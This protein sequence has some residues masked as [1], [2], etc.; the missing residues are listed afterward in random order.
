MID[1]YTRFWQPAALVVSDME[2]HGV[3]LAP[4]LCPLKAGEVEETLAELEVRLNDW[5]GPLAQPEFVFDETKVKE[6]KCRT[7]EEERELQYQKQWDR[8]Q[9]RL[10]NAPDKV[11]WSSTPQLAH[12]LYSTEPGPGVK[13]GYIITPKGFSVPPVKGTMRAVK[14][15]GAGD[16]PTSEASLRWMEAR[17]EDP[18]DREGLLALLEWKKQFKLHGFLTGLPEKAGFD[19]RIH[20]QLTLKTETGRLACKNPNLQNQPP[21]IRDVFVPSPGNVFICR[22]YDGLEWRI[23]AHILAWRYGDESLV[24]EIRGG[25]DPH[26]ATA[27][28]LYEALGMPLQIVMVD[29]VAV[30]YDPAV[31]RGMPTMACPL[32]L[33]KALFPKE[34]D[35][36]KIINYSINYGKTADGLGIQLRDD[37]GEPIGKE[38][39]QRML[40]AF[41]EGKPGVAQWHRDCILLARDSGYAQSVLGGRR[42]VPELRA[43][44]KWV[45]A[46]AE[47]VAMNTPIQRSAADIVMVAM[48]RCNPEPHPE[49]VELGWYNED[50]DKMGVKQILQVHDELLFECPKQ[51]A[52][53]ANALIEEAMENPLDGIREFLCPLTTSGDIGADWKEAGGKG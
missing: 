6:R 47:R 26:S 7:L 30:P 2:R 38:T 14:K 29:G 22:D 21:S 24:Q 41:Y 32:D 18:A 53:E 11:V 17:V 15:T 23:L 33:V 48:L 42:Y 25:I 20:P 10:A 35:A 3:G 13:D 4:N 44:S 52:E 8:Y 36:A 1:L 31:H 39:A 19:G 9:R 5:A 34:R 43:K 51:H 46:A 45:R 27:S 16:R 40:D 50:L 49:L 12:F 28:Q 37:H